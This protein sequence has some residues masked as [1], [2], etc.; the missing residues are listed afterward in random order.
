MNRTKSFFLILLALDVSDCEAF[1]GIPPPQSSPDRGN[2]LLSEYAMAQSGI[3]LNVVLDIPENVN[4]HDTTASRLVVD[5][6]KF[7]LITDAVL[8]GDVGNPL[9]QK[10]IST[11][12]RSSTS[13]SSSVLVSPPISTGPLGLKIHSD[14]K[15]VS[16]KGQQTVSFG[17]GSWKMNWV[18]N[19][20]LGEIVCGFY[21]ESDAIRNDA[22]LPSGHVYFSFPVFSKHSMEIFETKRIDYNKALNEYY[23]IQYEELDKMRNCKVLF[24]KLGYLKNGF[25]NYNGIMKLKSEFDLKVPTTE[26]NG[27]VLLSIGEDLFIS[28]KGSVWSK[29]PGK[30]MDLVLVGEA[31]L[32]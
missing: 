9:Q 16:M 14:G 4:C 6:L 31:S 5:G 1:L 2:P 12:R 26:R 10:P 17:K 20:L 24:K 28:T 27:G 32:K 19:S 30:E 3:L 8:A 13:S 18:D 23:R 15:F 7:E 21:L 29:S 22:V 25:D 11:T